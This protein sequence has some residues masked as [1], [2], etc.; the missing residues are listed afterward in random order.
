M[1]G[2]ASGEHGIGALKVKSAMAETPERI[3]QLQRDIKRI[4]DPRQIFNPGKKF[5]I[6][7]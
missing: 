6:D 3:L 2:T 1:G 7:S 4:L 5:S